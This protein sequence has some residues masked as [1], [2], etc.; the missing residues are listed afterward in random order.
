MA[1]RGAAVTARGAD[2]AARASSR[3]YYDAEAPVY[4]ETRGGPARAE[5]AAA[6]VAELVPTGGLLVDVAGGTGIVSAALAGRG[7]SVTVLDGSPGMLAVA[8]TRLPGRCAAAVADRLPLGEASVDVVTVIWLLH[9]LDV[10]TAD[11]VLAE[12]ARV[13][14]PGGHLVTTVDK[15]LAHGRVP[16]RPSDHRERVELV[17]GRHGLGFVG[18]TSF[19]ARSRWGSATEGDPVFPVAAFRTR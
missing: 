9:L 15:D 5:A 11:R 10:P 19:R 3:A 14:R 2:R 7:F 16:K 1:A 6:A 13:L 4:D 12:A 8:S 17:A 18:S